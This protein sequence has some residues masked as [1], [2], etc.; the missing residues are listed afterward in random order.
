[1]PALPEPHVPGGF[2]KYVGT[3]LQVLSKPHVPGDFDKHIGTLLQV[4]V[5]TG[6]CLT[7]LVLC[8]FA[9]TAL[10]SATKHHL[11]R[12]SFRLLTCALLAN[13]VYGCAF[14]STAKA[15]GPSPQC[16][17]TVFLINL[18]NL[19]SG[20]M[21]FCIALNLELVL[22]HGC[23]GKR[24]EKYYILGTLALSAICTIPPY[25]AG[26]FGWNELNQACWFNN[27]DQQAVVR[28]DIGTQVFW[29]LF[30]AIGE[31]VAVLLLV[32]YFVLYG[33]NQRRIHTGSTS[34]GTG[35]SST[36]SEHLPR[37]PMVQYRN[38]MAQYRNII[39]RVGLYPLVSCILS[40]GTIIDLYLLVYQAS[41]PIMT[42][43]NFRLTIASICI[44]AL[45][46][47]IYA[48]LAAT[49][50]SFVRALRELRR[51][52]EQLTV[53]QLQS[54]GLRGRFTSTEPAGPG[55][56][57]HIGFP[58]KAVTTDDAGANTLTH[59]SAEAP[60]EAPRQSPTSESKMGGEHLSGADVPEV[61]TWAVGADP[62]RAPALQV[63]SRRGPAP[64]VDVVSHI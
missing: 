48:V 10:H 34:S 61:D 19:F 46:L 39:L 30:M 45:R 25:A 57:L 18:T 58:S 38:P 4:L 55:E 13:L 41:H 36:R 24:L 54:S 60:K 33:S 7:I 28:W 56:S 44:Y 5:I 29:V 43:L 32:R 14:L 3:L 22:V 20:G 23:N 12:V 40:L 53:L 31:A 15:T 51:P 37:L 8:A 21:F 16:G 11:N 35:T 47:E 52:A 9:Y 17:L 50:P 59:A 26:Q 49:D 62:M 6:L 1:M 63:R 64:R 27:P 42:E 2:D